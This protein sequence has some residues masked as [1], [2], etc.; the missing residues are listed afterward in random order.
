MLIDYESIRE[1]DSGCNF[2]GMHGRYLMIGVV[3]Q[4]ALLNDH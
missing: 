4:K 2:F 3:M 1:M